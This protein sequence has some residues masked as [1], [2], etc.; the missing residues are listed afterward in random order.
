MAIR[1]AINGFGRIGRLT[2]R[3]L[4]QRQQEFEVVAVNDLT[5]NEMLATLLKYDSTHRRF[6]GD[7]GH[8]EKNLIVDGKPIQVFECRNPAELPWGDLGV[9]VVVESTGVFT[10]RAGNGKPG[11]DSHLDAGAK[12][13]CD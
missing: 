7:V 13:R 9:D 8:D 4:W 10:S 5:D 11:Y 6:A 2:F 3:N 1:V 12:T